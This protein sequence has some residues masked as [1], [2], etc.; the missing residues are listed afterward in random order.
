MTL[1]MTLRE[2]VGFVWIGDQPGIRVRLMAASLADARAQLV[3]DHGEGHVISIR[4]E[5]DASRPRF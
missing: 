4:N 3:A 2:Y 5:D 1:S